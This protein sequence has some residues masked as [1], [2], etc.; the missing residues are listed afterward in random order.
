MQQHLA[1]PDL[2]WV[3]GHLRDGVE[4]RPG[5]CPA[6]MLLLPV[7]GRRTTQALHLILTNHPVLRMPTEWGRASMGRLDSP[8]SPRHSAPPPSVRPGA[9][10]PVGP[11]PLYPVCAWCP[12]VPGYPLHS[13]MHRVSTGPRVPRHVPESTLRRHRMLQDVRAPHSTMENPRNSV[14]SRVTPAQWNPQA[15]AWQCREQVTMPQTG[16]AGGPMVGVRPAAATSR[17]RP[18]TRSALEPNSSDHNHQFPGGKQGAGP[19][20]HPISPD[21]IID[22]ASGTAQSGP[23]HYEN[24]ELAARTRPQLPVLGDGSHS[25]NE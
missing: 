16:G 20:F 11:G 7:D 25:R 24:C 4:E 18:V 1:G 9:Q 14:N 6:C 10:A 8:L 3:P 17:P 15:A 19:S 23:F 13:G 21:K 12:Q 5:P 2:G 22:W